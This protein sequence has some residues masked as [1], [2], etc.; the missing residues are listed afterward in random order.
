MN[1]PWENWS[2]VLKSRK[3]DKTTKCRGTVGKFLYFFFIRQSSCIQEEYKWQRKIVYSKWANLALLFSV[4]CQGS[5]FFLRIQ[6]QPS[7]SLVVY[8]F[9]FRLYTNVSCLVATAA[10]LT[11]C[12]PLVWQW[13]T[14]WLWWLLQEYNI[15]EK[16]KHLLYSRL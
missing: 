11:L 4:V 10:L 9:L 2:S 8:I 7:S 15:V 12:L 14:I 13:M 1:P 6:P 3:M 5:F 16:L